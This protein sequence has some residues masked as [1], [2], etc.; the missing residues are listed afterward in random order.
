MIRL[1]L[2]RTGSAVLG[3]ALLAGGLTAGLVAPAPGAAAH[4][5]PDPL[6]AANAADWLS[7]QLV[8]GALQG[9]FGPSWGVTIDGAFAFDA[10]GGHEADVAAISDA[11]AAHIN[12]YIVQAYSFGG[13]DYST[14]V[15]GSTAKAAAFADLAGGDPRAFGE[16]DLIAIVEGMVE[17]SGRIEDRATIDGQPDPNG[18]Y[19]NVIGQT[20]AARALADAGSPSADEVISFLLKQQCSEGWFRQDFTR[21]ENDEDPYNS[22]PATDGRCRSANAGSESNVDATAL[23]VVILEPLADSNPLIDDA[24]ANAITWLMSVQKAN[25]SF[26]L[27]GGI[28]P[29]SNSTSLAAWALRVTDMHEHAETAAAWVRRQQVTGTACDG[30]VSEDLGAVAYSGAD[31]TA[32]RAEGITPAKAPTWTRTTAQAI[33]GLLAAPATDVALR[34]DAPAFADA[35]GQ[36]ALKVRGLAPGERAC[37][38]LGETTSGVVGTEVGGVQTVKVAVADAEGP[39]QP[40]VDAADA[41]DATASY[42]LPALKV[43]FTLKAEVRAN[44][45]QTITATGLHAGEKVVVRLGDTKVAGGVAAGDGTFTATFPVGDDAGRA[46]VTVRGQFA[47]RTNTKAFQVL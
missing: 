25:G 6:P 36:V 16:K 31:L 4:G 43:P 45:N 1:A 40:G 41:S 2:R 33:P 38:R 35:G 9:S 27:G 26:A 44:R 3:G 19:A 20:F 8:D 47:D 15:A 18:D 39:L 46:K 11:L 21:P 7:D 34:I 30:S 5:E 12:D 17:D 29:N 28:G 23:A 32:A 14:D 22:P 24:L 37:V 42:A 10:V 13:V